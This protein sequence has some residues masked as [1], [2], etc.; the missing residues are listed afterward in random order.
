M[1]QSRVHSCTFQE[2]VAMGK[3]EPRASKKCNCRKLVDYAE[4]NEMVKFGEA[5]WVVVERERGGQ[6][7]SCKLC[8]GFEPSPNCEVCKGTGRMTIPVSWDTYN[9]DIVMVNHRTKSARFSTPRVPTIESKHII[10]AYVEGNAAAAQRIEEFNQLTQEQAHEYGASLSVRIT[11]KRVGQLYKVG[12][13]EYLTALDM[14]EV[15]SGL[16][17]PPNSSKGFPPGTIT[18]KDGTKNK[19]WYWKQDGR[20]VDF[21]RAI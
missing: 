6:E 18:F 5:L 1:A 21:G 11:R 9:T 8:Q 20:D 3:M 13:T 4:A 10:R 16:P 7:T 15:R 19:T 2:L 17:E 14:R 12:D